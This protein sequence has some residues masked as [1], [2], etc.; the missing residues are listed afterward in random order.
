M[1]DLKKSIEMDVTAKVHADTK[2]AERETKEAIEG[3]QYTIDIGIDKK[4]I[5]GLFNELDNYLIGMNKNLKGLDFKKVFGSG[6]GVINGQVQELDDMQTSL[7]KAADRVQFLRNNL[8]QV[9]QQIGKTDEGKDIMGLRVTGDEL[10]NINDNVDAVTKAMAAMVDT[11]IDVQSFE[12]LKTTLTQIRDTLI[13]ISGIKL[14]PSED[15]MKEITNL[16]AQLLDSKKGGLGKVAKDYEKSYKYLTSKKA[17]EAAEAA[18]TNRDLMFDD[19][20]FKNLDTY[21]KLGG[22]LSDIQFNKP[23]EIKYDSKNAKGNV[24]QITKLVSNLQQY[25]DIVRKLTTMKNVDVISGNLQTMKSLGDENTPIGKLEAARQQRQRL[26]RDYD[27]A[28][29]NEDRM[30]AKK[31]EAEAAKL[32]AEADKEGA[33]GSGGFNTEE[34]NK[35]VESL[36]EAVSK[37]SDAQGKVTEL[38][39]KIS[40]AI[41]VDKPLDIPIEPKADDVGGF[42][43]KIQNALE[44]QNVKIGVEV[45]PNNI[46]MGSGSSGATPSK[47]SNE[48]QDV[49]AENIKPGI[50]DTLKKKIEPY[51]LSIN[52]LIKKTYGATEVPYW[53][54]KDIDKSQKES[55]AITYQRLKGIYK[56][57][58]VAESE[59]KDQFAIDNAWDSIQKLKLGSARGKNITEIL[60]G[61]KQQDQIFTAKDLSNAQRFNVTLDEC[62]EKIRAYHNEQISSGSYPDLFSTQEAQMYM[63]QAL[64]LSGDKETLDRA[65]KKSGLNLGF[66]DTK[67]FIDSHW[68]PRDSDLKTLNILKSGIM[69]NIEILPN[70]DD[71]YNISGY[72]AYKKGT[73]EEVD[74]NDILN[75]RAQNSIKSVSDN[76]NS[77]SGKGN[78]EI[79]VTFKP[80]EGSS[81]SLISQVQSEAEG[82]SIHLNVEPIEGAGAD[83]VSKIQSEIGEQKVQI[84]FKPLETDA[85]A[86]ISSIQSSLTGKEVELTVKGVNDESE[87]TENKP[88]GGGKPEDPNKKGRGEGEGRG[89]KYRGMT[90]DVFLENYDLSQYN[91]LFN[92]VGLGDFK[93]LISFGE[94]G[95]AVVAFNEGLAE[96]IVR[97]EDLVEVSD[98]LKKGTFNKDDFKNSYTQIDKDAVKEAERQER[99]REKAQERQQKAQERQQKENKRLQEQ[100]IKDKERQND[101]EAKEAQRIVREEAAAKEAERQRLIK[102]DQ[103]MQKYQIQRAGQ[104]I[105]EE[106]KLKEQQRKDQ[107]QQQLKSEAAINKTASELS[108]ANFKETMA[109]YKA[110]LDAI[111]KGQEVSG[112]QTDVMK[113]IRE[114]YGT[115]K[116]TRS[117]LNPENTGDRELVNSV[118]RVSNA[119]LRSTVG[120]ERTDLQKFTDVD[121][122]KIAGFADKLKD[123]KGYVDQLQG[124]TIDW[125]DEK[126]IADLQKLLEL[127]KLTKS[128]L[129]DMQK[130]SNISENAQ[131]QA[132]AK[133]LRQ[134]EQEQAKAARDAEKQRA[135]QQAEYEKLFNQSSIRDYF[136]KN[137]IIEGLG[138]FEGVKFDGNTAVLSFFNELDGKVTQTTVKVKDLDAAIQ[139]VERGNFAEYA[140]TLN[141]VT[142]DVQ[143][144]KQQNE[145][146]KNARAGYAAQLSGKEMT[147]VQ[148]SALDNIVQAYQRIVEAGDQATA[149]DRQ[150]KAQIESMPQLAYQDFMKTQVDQLNNLNAKK[151]MFDTYYAEVEKIR[152]A[153]NNLNNTTFDP[154]DEKQKADIQ[155]LLNMYTELENRVKSGEFTPASEKSISALQTRFATIKEFNSKAARSGAFK[156]QFN[157][158]GAQIGD[159]NTKN[160]VKDVNELS[161]QLNVLRGNLT[162]AG[163]TGM[164]FFDTWKQ[165]MGSLGAYLASFASFY[166]IIG[167]IKDTANE[168]R[169]FDT[170]LT[171]MRKVS[172]ESVQSLRNFQEV[173]FD[174]ASNIGT[175]ALQLQQSTAD[176]LRLGESFDEAQKSAESANILMNVSEFSSIDEATESLISMSA[177]YDDLEKIDIVDKLNLIGNNFSISTDQLA[178]GLK[179]SAA[180]LSTAGNDINESIA[181]ITAGNA[182]TQNASKTGAGL[183][184]I[185]LR[186]AGTEAAKKELEDIGEDTT[187]FVVQTKSKI[188]EQLRQFTAVGSNDYKGVSMLSDDGTYKSTYQVLQEIADIYDEIIESDKKFGTNKA[189]GLLELIA[190]KTRANI[191]G[192]I[193]QNP[194]ILRSAYEQVQNA[195][196]SAME[197]NEKY[198]DSIDGKISQLQTRISE[199]QTS[200]FTSDMF[201]GLIEGATEFLE[202]LNNIIDTIGLFP[203]LAGA[204]GLVGLTSAIPYIANAGANDF[205]IQTLRSKLQNNKFD[206]LD[207]VNTFALDHNLNQKNVENLINETGWKELSARTAEA[208]ASTERMATAATLSGTAMNETA[209]SGQ[210]VQEAMAGTTAEAAMLAGTEGTVASEATL[211]AGAQ[212]ETAAAT[213]TAAGEAEVL[214]GAEATAATAAEALSSETEL[215]AGSTA[216]AAL[217]AEEVA[218]ATGVAATNAERLAAGYADAA[219]AAAEASFTSELNAKQSAFTAANNGVLLGSIT[220]SNANSG[221]VKLADAADDLEEFAGTTGAAALQMEG[222]EAAAG[223]V[224][225]GTAAANTGFSRL[226]ETVKKIGSFLFKWKFA[227]GGI[228]ALLAAISVAKWY[229]KDYDRKSEKFDE[230][231]EKYSKDLTELDKTD[232]KIQ[233][234]NS[235]IDEINSKDKLTFTDKAELA[236]LEAQKRELEDMRNIQQELVDSEKKRASDSA[237]KALNS[238]K[239]TVD[240]TKSGLPAGVYDPTKK[241]YGKSKLVEGQLNNLKALK[242]AQEE[243]DEAQKAYDEDEK[244]GKIRP[245]VQKRYDNAKK[246]V[247]DI[248]DALTKG[249][250]EMAKYKDTLDLS[251]DKAADAYHQIES[252]IQQT[253]NALSDTKDP[254]DLMRKNIESAFTSTDEATNKSR[255][256]LKQY[257]TDAVNDG[258]SA[259]EALAEIGYTVEDINLYDIADGA[260]GTI[261]AVESL[262]S[263]FDD[264]K[265]NADETKAK[266][267]EVFEVDGSFEGVKAAQES[268]N[269]GANWESMAGWL[270]NGKDLYKK[271]LV[272]TDDFQTLAQFMSPKQIKV[273]EGFN[274]DAYI[275]AWKKAQKKIK[276]YFDSEN[277]MDSMIN[278]RDD[279]VEK[280]VMKWVNKETGETKNTFETTAEAAE[281]M[282]LSVQATE[283]I[284]NRLKDYGFEFTGIEWSGQKLDE[285]RQNLENVQQLYESMKPGE[286]K[287]RLGLL[288]QGFD[289]E[290]EKYQEDLGELDDE[291]IVKIKF[292]YDLSQ[293]LYDLNQLQQDALNNGWSKENASSQIMKL[294]EGRDLLEKQTGITASNNRGYGASFDKINDINS[295]LKLASTTEARREE[296][297]QEKQAI[298]ELQLSYQQLLASGESMDWS[299][300]IEGNMDQILAEKLPEF[301]QNVKD[302]LQG[303]ID[304]TT[305][306]TSKDDKTTS[307]YNNGSAEQQAKNN[308]KL[309]KAFTENFNAGKDVEQ[310]YKKLEAAAKKQGTTVEKLASKYKGGTK[311][312]K[313]Y[314]KQQ[315]EANKERS[316]SERDSSTSSKTETKTETTPKKTE[317]Q[318]QP[319]KSTLQ[320]PLANPVI[321]PQVD[322]SKAQAEL[323]EFTSIPQAQTIVAELIGEDNATPIIDAWNQLEADEQFATLTGEDQAT[324]IIGLWNSL[325]PIPQFAEL[326]GKDKATWVINAWNTL[327]PEEK[328]ALIRGDNKDALNK[329]QSVINKN[330]PNKHFNIA[331]NGAETAKSAIS[332]IVSKMRELKD[333]TVNLVT[334]KK[335]IVSTERGNHGK[336]G[337]ETEHLHGTAHASGTPSWISGLPD[338]SLKHTPIDTNNYPKK[339]QT[340]SDENALVGEVAPEMVV[341]GNRWWLVGENGPEF[342]HIPAHSVVFNSKQTEELLN[343]GSTSTRGKSNLHGSAFAHGST[344]DDEDYYYDDFEF[345]DDEDEDYYAYIGGTAYLGKNGGKLNRTS[346][347]SSSST[348]SGGGKKTSK[349]SG[350]K[351]SGKKGNKNGS[352]KD[353][354]WDAFQK[355]V[356]SLFDWVEIRLEHL[357]DLTAQW[358]T[359]AEKAVNQGSETQRNFYNKAIS[360]L[361]KELN[362]NSSAASGYK[363]KAKSVGK[364]GVEVYNKKAKKGDKIDNKNNKWVNKIVEDLEK[365]RI[366]K[367][368]KGQFTKSTIASYG[369]KRMSL[370][371]DIDTWYQKSKTASKAVIDLTDNLQELYTKLKDIPNVKADKAVEKLNKELEDLKRNSERNSKY[372]YRN[373]KDGKTTAIGQMNADLNSETTNLKNQMGERQTAYNTTQSDLKS[374]SKNAKNVIKNSKINKKDKKKYQDAIDKR[375]K[376]EIKDSWSTKTKKAVAA[377]NASIDANVTAHDNFLV[378]EDAYLDAFYENAAKRLENI[379]NWYDKIGETFS[380]RASE[381]ESYVELGK[382]RGQLFTS[383]STPFAIEEQA[384]KNAVSNAESNLS[385][386]EAE[387]LEQIKSGELKKGTQQWY[388]M[389]AQLTSLRGATFD[390]KKDLK[391]FQNTLVRLDFTNLQNQL[392]R[393]QDTIDRLS[394]RNDYAERI[395]GKYF[396]DRADKAIFRYDETALQEQLNA[397][398]AAIEKSTEV[399]EKAIEQM[400]NLEIGSEEWNQ[401]NEDAKQASESIFSAANAIEDLSDKIVELR[402]KPFRDFLETLT[403]TTSELETIREFINKDNLVGK[404]G[405]FTDDTYAD[406]AMLTELIENS[407]KIISNYRIALDKVQEDLD[408]GNITQEKAIEL[409]NEYMD[410]ISEEAKR[411]ADYRGE[412]LELY[413]DQLERENELLQENIDLRREIICAY[414][415]NCWNTLRVS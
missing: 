70:Y 241:V 273:T 242:E 163:K 201:K 101:A 126:Q 269:A 65:M 275:E 231:N 80:A 150:F 78:F 209:M 189:N 330:I 50:S 129:S 167:V 312:I 108:K 175:T 288:L 354:A 412:I 351:K 325:S 388:E 90:K 232:K 352:K 173:S 71:N 291:A 182:I 115:A 180:A 100:A 316:Y 222:I 47:I 15:I 110:G 208:A 20:F 271:G 278:F 2:E 177:A 181:L 266:I 280:G 253:S 210:A 27:T 132:D 87:K 35:F 279:A 96:T 138:T 51:N 88:A 117:Y 404:D 6:K 172:D 214:S 162:A 19:K 373:S 237:L 155:E 187:D 218:T 102:E 205:A 22:K 378:A 136:S 309:A 134:Q 82:Q 146:L 328:K 311:A 95:D 17:A 66:K 179:D 262:N 12:E 186:M 347:S 380:A 230:D 307:K 74:I 254:T 408:N 298:E 357:K 387:V 7:Q 8:L 284:L 386:Y 335:T 56:S 272:G 229:E 68:V 238:D 304:E 371:K 116:Q 338:K 322:L 246:R 290:Y 228:A 24:E 85:D 212:T 34:I 194:E 170:A 61:L 144:T 336:G 250:T 321:V 372:V 123:L 405:G 23:I 343:N 350:G 161:N 40:E 190:G 249:S 165:R 396:G 131:K 302:E 248:T 91:D 10:R 301:K 360:S 257:L 375:Q 188:D 203:T 334:H 406:L 191:A 207:E 361:T 41:H 234:I 308:K 263:Y 29:V 392:K 240:Y 67:D 320:A 48:I 391:E 124:M 142:K 30:A 296:L 332:S 277:P 11:K 370:I 83:F 143:L 60:N 25:Y 37:L 92:D 148:T 225:A 323:N 55:L 94:D 236:N 97:F 219:G 195:E 233:D 79:P 178:T 407:N 355:W 274:S 366:K 52:D 46:K 341:N 292:E 9:T 313:E 223:G 287:D 157:N 289:Q 174:L 260:G 368:K 216:A 235:R 403:R 193:L 125:S 196:G 305:G 270:K 326:N 54:P 367:N 243:L 5:Q 153:I 21:T 197:E 259:S 149:A 192:S 59:L 211:A 1:A 324:A 135:D 251:D 111:L 184:T 112:V 276:R 185:S 198:L 264:L 145:D 104:R 226:L 58:G 393:I 244:K 156:D 390:A 402:W 107:E 286:A 331:A 26:Q 113:Q 293:V 159:L 45:D 401:W 383:Q 168:V 89:N 128:E 329:I 202:L 72:K 267:K 81:S 252:A 306:K 346:S 84:G 317:T 93:K 261:S 38:Q 217:E 106:D 294:E 13:D 139:S 239:G 103:E 4:Q 16:D 31:A 75:N 119:A 137:K 414:S 410:G 166:R 33:G 171:E 215:L 281:K 394:T 342:T 28:K 345:Y 364:K 398:F 382:A 363:K 86:F 374:S 39:S 200:V 158:L 349:K 53:N 3:K 353:K 400:A 133:L 397:N 340:K 109:D 62:I 385:K 282:G 73:I 283:T 362:A 339:W 389:E 160:S 303:T 199:L 221:V 152:E 365:G 268:E 258:K 376:I 337:T 63:Q 147:P 77:V 224:A 384:K 315:I 285:Y 164:S 127:I 395:S 411:I 369:E 176:F 213:G 299:T 183:R 32:A 295:E 399:Y 14:A 206:T 344:L 300:F 57:F 220:G 359:A 245:E 44:G 69:R 64:L 169:Q 121:S 256:E 409:Q 76:A 204:G 105:K 43:G 310:Q 381:V 265:V 154:N 356:S 130:A 141:P 413:Y 151:G 297:L 314:K 379:N 377:Y 36:T 98:K 42:V 333:K 114:A 118:E 415:F 18:A 49:I 227:I 358:T 99:E 318:S 122:S 255:Q 319:K 140:Q 348:S 327:S 120:K 247:D